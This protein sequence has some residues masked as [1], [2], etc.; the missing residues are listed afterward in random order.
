[1]FSVKPPKSKLNVRKMKTVAICQSNYIPWKG[2]FDMLA[3]V[4]EFV[5]YDDVQYTRRDWRNRNR[6]KTPN[7]L[8]WLS[9]PVEVKG[10]YEQKVR[11]TAIAGNKWAASHW[12]SIKAN[13]AEA[14]YFGEVADWLEPIYKNESFAFLS[15]L[16]RRLIEAVCQYLSIDTLI[17]N[18]WDYELLGDRTERLVG[19]CAQARADKYV[20][21]PAAKSYMDLDAFTQRGISVSW[22]DYDDYPEYEQLWGKFEHRVS[23]LDLLFNCGVASRHF[24]R[25]VG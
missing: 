4:D 2:Y 8:R 13:Y 12:G 21:G 22:Y 3:L 25:H 14:P 7:G 11:E 18:S 23:I 17:S 6:I 19:I 9:V 1:M 16:N 20:S 10:K 15:T 5:L 24:L